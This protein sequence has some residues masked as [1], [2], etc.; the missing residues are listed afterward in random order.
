[1]RWTNV[2]DWLPGRIEKQ[3]RERWHNH[4]NPWIK[5]GAW[6]HEEE[7]I[8]YLLNR[9][10]KNKWAEIAQELEFRSDNTIKNR[11]NTTMKRKIKV[12]EAEVE[13]EF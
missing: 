3:C 7:L 2:A 12:F 5:K 13:D 6:S 11:W 8:L 4:L 10:K 1:M 9:E